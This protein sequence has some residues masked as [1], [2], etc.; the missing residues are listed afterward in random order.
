MKA[1][2]WGGKL[3]GI[4]EDFAK[5]TQEERKALFPV[6]KHLEKKLGADC[7]VFIAYPAILK[8]TDANGR[9][10]IATEKEIERM[11]DEIEKDK[12]SK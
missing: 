11:R 8:Y 2:P 6:K 4:S 3:I 1:N 10:K 12:E 5:K 7:K 9:V